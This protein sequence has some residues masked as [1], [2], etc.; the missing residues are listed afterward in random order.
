M[1]PH[2]TKIPE[3]SIVIPVFN[4][5]EFLSRCLESIRNLNFSKEHNYEVLILDNGSTDATHSIL[6][7]FGLEFQIAPGITISALR[8]RGAAMARGD[9]LAFVDADVELS[10]SWLEEGLRCFANPK[11]VASG[12]PPRAPKRASWVQQT[13]DLHRHRNHRGLR[14][15]PVDW[16]PSMNLLVRRNDFVAVCGFNEGLETSE[17]VDLC[18]RLKHR[19]KILCNP[20]LGAVHL[21]EARTLRIFWRKQVWHGKGNFKGVLSHGLCWDEVPSLGY[22]LYVLL[23]LSLLLGVNFITDVWRPRIL[24]IPL[25]CTLL[26]FPGAVLAVR[27][28]Y[29]TKCVGRL[30][31]F[32]LLYTVYGFARAWSAMSS[33][34]AIFMLI[35]GDSLRK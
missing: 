12:F 34:S 26:V 31:K 10:P 16:L 6:R 27:T 3:V 1:G 30:H 28:A 21:G 22:P 9:F 33:V 19:G 13:W 2:Q 32:F 29:L 18:Y 35:K 11:I 4:G 14:P 24:L 8:N 25:L 15:F 20:A 23:C 5:E 17:D 7:Q